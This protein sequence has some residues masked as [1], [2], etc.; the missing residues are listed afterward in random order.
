MMEEILPES[1]TMPADECALNKGRR[2][3]SFGA[4]AARRYR[5]DKYQ[6]V[7]VYHE[8]ELLFIQFHA[9]NGGKYT[10]RRPTHGDGREFSC[11]AL[12]KKLDI[13]TGHYPLT[14]DQGS[15]MLRIAWTMPVRPLRAGRRIYR[16][17]IMDRHHKTGFWERLIGVVTQ[18]KRGFYLSSSSLM[19]AVRLGKLVAL[20]AGGVLRNPARELLVRVF[21]HAAWARA[22]SY[23]QEEVTY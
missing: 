4:R 7:R 19:R 5:L 1:H 20:D 6:S 21:A 2:T 18:S 16:G 8:G 3:V 12:F 22:R 17:Q 10:L 13:Q 11:T 15:G 14:K 23:K 9:G